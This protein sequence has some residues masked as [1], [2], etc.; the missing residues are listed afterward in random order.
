[1]SQTKFPLGRIVLTANAAN[2]LAHNDL[3]VGLLR[4]VAG[5]WGDLEEPDR[6]ENEKALLNSFRLLSSYCAITGIKF[7]IITE[8]DRSVTNVELHISHLMLSLQKC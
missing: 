1:M 6:Q 2:V 7:W 3:E 8:A 5:D 4:H